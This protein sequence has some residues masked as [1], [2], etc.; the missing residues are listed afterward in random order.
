MERIRHVEAGEGQ[1]LTP[2][3]RPGRPT[4]ASNQEHFPGWREAGGGKAGGGGG[5]GRNK[6]EEGEMGGGKRKR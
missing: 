1:A 6:E 4:M 5:G 3:Q 2:T